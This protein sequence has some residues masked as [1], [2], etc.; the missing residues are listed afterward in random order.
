MK[1]KLL[2]AILGIVLILA[3]VGAFSLTFPSSLSLSNSQTSALFTISNTNSQDV[4]LTFQGPYTIT[5]GFGHTVAFTLNPALTNYNLPAG[6][7]TQFNV[8]LIA[9]VDS[10]FG[11]GTF[12]KAFTL[13]VANASNLSNIEAKSMSVSFNKDY[14]SAGKVG[15]LKINKFDI[16]NKEGYGEDKD[17]YFLDKLEVDVEVKNTGNEDIDNVV[18]Q[19]GLYN[20]RTG[21]FVFEN[22]E[23]DFDLRDRDTETVTLSFDVDPNDF[24]SS[25]GEN[26]FVLYIKAY[27]DDV[28]EDGQCVSDSENIKL[29]RDNHFVVLSDIQLPDQVQCGEIV[30]GR[31]KVWNIGDD[32]ET[33]I[34]V[35]LSNSNLGLDKRVDVGDVD[36]LED[37]S[38]TFDFLVPQNMKSI[39]YPIQMKVYDD[40]DEVYLNDNDDEATFS[41]TLAVKGSCTGDVPEGAVDISAVLDSESIAGNEMTVKATLTNRGTAE[42]TYQIIATNYDSWASL[43]NVDP[44]S[45]T[46]APGA[47]KESVITLTPNDDV[48]GSKEFT[49]QAV[50]NG[51]ITEQRVGVE[52][53]PKKSSGFFSFTGFSISESFKDN[54]FIWL[55]A[56]LNVILVIFIV[57]VAVRVLKR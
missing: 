55:I 41:K 30:Q 7:S 53:E 15:N 31:A 45:L 32:D 34:Y 9:P 28:G 39:S 11:L 40:S 38:I 4:V 51:K 49:I 5:D 29:I 33:D 21:E 57:V 14:C 52:V 46:L 6:N 56:A 17:W 16:N 10:S 3:L 23:N 13:N 37:K 26:D 27:S 12:T 1:A 8:S 25:D 48:S 2:S 50:Y 54:W 47:S 20:K 43:E 36:I 18:V 35:K 22:D 44:K 42:T 24:D 19:W